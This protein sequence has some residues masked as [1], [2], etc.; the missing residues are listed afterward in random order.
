MVAVQVTWPLFEGGVTYSKIRE[1]RA[2]LKELEARGEQL[3]LDI[4]LEVTH[5]VLAVEEATEKIHVAD[6]R[7]IWAQ[8]ALE[9]IRYLYRSEAATVDTLLQTELAWNE[10]EVSYA[11]AV[12][13]GKIAQALLKR[14][15]GDFADRVQ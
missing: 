3:A 15:L 7:R 5:A 14:S 8:K 4:A 12:F 6:E 2:R 9:E 10:A 11:G 13:E 1:A